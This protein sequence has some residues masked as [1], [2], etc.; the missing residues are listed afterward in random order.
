MTIKLGNGI[1]LLPSKL[2]IKTGGIE[3]NKEEILE[4]SRK[5][6]ND[7]YEIKTFKDGQ[8]IGIILI[9]VTCFFFTLTNAVISDLK[10]LETGIISF[11]YAAILFAYI[12]GSNFYRYAK[13]KNKNDLIAGIAFA[14]VF[15]CML[16]LYLYYINM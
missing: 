9:F 16:I 1:I 4:R 10:G 14:L 15:V 2:G 3:M 11:D 6:K 7:E 8:T 5:D 12:S 13:L